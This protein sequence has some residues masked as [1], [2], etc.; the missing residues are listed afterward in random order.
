M[1]F[2]ERLFIPG[3]ECPFCNAVSLQQFCNVASCIKTSAFSPIFKS[4]S[5]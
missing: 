5:E 2:V 3:V 4:S 1:T